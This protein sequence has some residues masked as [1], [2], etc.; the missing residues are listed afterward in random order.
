MVVHTK[1]KTTGW[2]SSGVIGD[3]CRRCHKTDSS[4]IAH[5]GKPLHV[6]EHC[7]DKRKIKLHKRNGTILDG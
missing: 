7:R 3:E 6:C 5:N 4:M 1:R 2:H